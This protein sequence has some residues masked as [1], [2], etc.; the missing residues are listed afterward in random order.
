MS[1]RSLLIRAMPCIACAIRRVQQPSPTEAHHC[2]V[3][4]R[5]GQKRVGDHAQ[6]PLCRYHHRGDPPYGMTATEATEIF[7]PSLARSSKAFRVEF[8]TDD[9]LLRRV[10]ERLERIG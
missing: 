8:G 2:N 1:A 7:G 4:G 10:N 9:E 6:L 5:A 3:G